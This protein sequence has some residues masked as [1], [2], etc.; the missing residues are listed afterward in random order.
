MI[1]IHFDY[2]KSAIINADA[3]EYIMKTCLQQTNNQKWKQLIVCY[4]WKLMSIEQ[5]YDIH[6]QEMLAIVKALEQWRIYLLETK[7][8]TIIKSDHKNL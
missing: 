3:S 5:Q 4:T 6:D 2:K 1:L 8:Q 7:H